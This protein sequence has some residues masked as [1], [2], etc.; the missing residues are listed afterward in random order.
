[1]RYCSLRLLT[2]GDNNALSDESLYPVG[3][4]SATRQ[5][6][7]GLVAGY[8]PFIG[9]AA[10]AFQETAWMKFVLLGIVLVVLAN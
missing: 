8:V 2:K 7:V 1:M 5:E 10:I 4:T 3:R 6:V 9:W